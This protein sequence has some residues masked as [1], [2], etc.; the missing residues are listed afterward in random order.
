MRPSV[1]S[2]LEAMKLWTLACSEG[3]VGG[4]DKE[5]LVMWLKRLELTLVASVVLVTASGSDAAETQRLRIQDC[6]HVVV[7]YV[8][9]HA[10][11]T[12]ANVGIWNWGD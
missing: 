12:P 4:L 2:T 6:R 1:K 5:N 10:A 3:M 11:M 9:G 7:Y 8:P